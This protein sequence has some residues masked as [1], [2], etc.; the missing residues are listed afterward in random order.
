MQQLTL[1]VRQRRA[2]A[3]IC[4][5]LCP[6]GDGLPSA[7]ELGVPEAVLALV[8]RDPRP[9]ARRELKQLLSAWDSAPLTYAIGH[10]WNR[11][12]ALP[13]ERREQALLSWCDS[14]LPQRRA[15]FQALRKGALLMYWAL[16]AR[17][18]GPN[19]AWAGIGLPAPP[20]P[21][22]DAPP[23]V[24]RPL[25]APPAGTTLECDVAI[26]GS[27]AGGGVAA[28]VLSAAGLDVIVIEAGGHWEEQDFDGGELRALTQF[29]AGSPTATHDQG[30]A[31]IAGACLGGG[32]V[33]NYSTSFRTPDDVRAEWAAHGVPAFAGDDY[34]ASLDAVVA[35]L[36]VNQEHNDPSTRDQKLRAGALA[37]GW[38]VDAMPRNVD[39]RCDMGEQCGRC[40][41]GCRN[42]AKQSVVKTWLRD[43]AGAGA[44]LLVGTKVEQV[45]IEQGSARGV[46]ARTAA[47]GELTIRARAV[48]AACGALHTPALLLRS[49]LQNQHLGKHLKLHPA[50][51]VWGV[52]DEELRPWEGRCRRSTPTST[53]T[54]TATATASSTRRPPRCRTWRCRSSR[55]AR[56]VS[57]TS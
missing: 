29:Y 7:S 54:S 10:G 33:V 16:P 17:D 52:Y 24:L 14:R 26:V 5:T 22:A 6:A 57:I 47:G 56:G 19:P 39:G 21:P 20:G 43:A 15:A 49:G 3:T 13:Q 28:A 36:G 42:G 45:L 46:R 40:G 50:T 4:D 2:L 51:A 27:G 41:L 38:H 23:K 12:G 44:R 32:T 1:S 35:R 53:A 25:A 37:L 31:L 8:A 11:F 34:G 48:V 55:G 18:G 30:V 9:A